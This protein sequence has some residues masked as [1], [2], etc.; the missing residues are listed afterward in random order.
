M[1][2][3]IISNKENE[4]IMNI[5][6]SLEESDFMTKGVSETIENE[7][8][9]QKCRFLGMLLGTLSAIL[10]KCTIASKVV[11][12]AG[13]GIIW[14]GEGVIS[15]SCGQRKGNTGPDFRFRLTLLLILK[16]KIIIEMSHDL[17]VFIEEIIQLK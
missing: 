1:T 13:K 7:A 10:L 11:I 2:T 6:K 15:P 8:K 4:D 17:I 14:A 12:R 5:V 3:L 16:Y 9:E